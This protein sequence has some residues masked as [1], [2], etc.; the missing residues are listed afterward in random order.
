ME[1][2]STPPHHVGFRAKNLLSG[3][4]G[5]ITDIAM[6]YIEQGG[7]GP[8][9][10]HTHLHD[11]VFVVLEGVATIYIGETKHRVGKEEAIRVPGCEMHSVWNREM[12]ALRMLGIT[13]APE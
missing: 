8:E 9:P 13:V 3:L 2:Y 5:E 7:G 11:H 10:A 1:E 4:Q 12:V 6:A